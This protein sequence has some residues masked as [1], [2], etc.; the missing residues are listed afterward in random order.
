MTCG[1]WLRLR[2]NVTKL[3]S[4][5]TLAGSVVS[6][7][8]YERTYIQVT[9]KALKTAI[10][11]NKGMTALGDIILHENLW[12]PPDFIYLF[13]L[14]TFG[15]DKVSVKQKIFFKLYKISTNPVLS[16]SSITFSVHFTELH[17][18]NI[19]FNI[20]HYN[21]FLPSQLHFICPRNSTVMKKLSSN[22]H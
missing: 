20:W 6:G 3:D 13:N 12:S 10:K 1:A 17:R 16:L 19:W 22:R 9:V 15:M 5:R 4:D 7:G 14:N 8:I 2:W 18:E 11:L 21:P